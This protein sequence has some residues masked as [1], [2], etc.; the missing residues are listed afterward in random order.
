VSATDR[1]STA[2]NLVQ[3]ACIVISFVIVAEV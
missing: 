1:K 3:C 2:V